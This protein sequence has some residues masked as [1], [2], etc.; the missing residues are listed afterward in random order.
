VKPSG[1]RYTV[2]ASLPAAIAVRAEA[3][4]SVIL[5]GGQSLIPTMNFR[6]ANP[7]VVIDLSRVPGLD[8]I[9]VSGGSVRVGAMA[10]QR[11]V[12]RSPEVF[13]ANPLIRETLRHVAHPAIRNRGTICG[14]LAHADPS[15]E[16]PALLSA[17][18]GTVTAQ[19]PGGRRVIPA[20]EFFEFIFTTSLEPE[21]LVVEA[22]FPALEPG[23]GWAFGE[24]AR[25]HGDFA[26][27]GVAATLLLGDDGRIAR[28][29]LAACGVSSVPVVLTECEELLAGQ[30]P[31]PA[32]F[33]EAGRLA[34]NAVTVSDDST[35]TAAY[36]RHVL[37][38]IVEKTLRTAL[39]RTGE[40]R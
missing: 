34:Q 30:D 3:E 6:L 14:S 27:A 18:R 22:E 17:T 39:S 16:L 26:V 23:E 36:R 15:A 31:A 33:A 7:Q 5:A 24:F 9:D 32:V 4:D 40:R 2:P 10:R 12:E 37:A 38:G 29:R 28:A 19:G 1:F 20:A 35:T 13:A 25:R 11:A 21:E 8:R